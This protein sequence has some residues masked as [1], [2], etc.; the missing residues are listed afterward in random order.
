MINRLSKAKS[1]KAQPK[2]GKPA[3][4]SRIV[5]SA[6]TAV[7]AQIEQLSASDWT[8]R[9]AAAR[10]LGKLGGRQATSALCGA[11]RDPAAEVAREA[12][13]ALGEIR[14]TPAVP[15]LAAVVLNA[16][17]Y[18][19][20]SVRTAAAEAL[21]K[22]QDH[23]AVEALITAVYDSLAEVSQAAIRA[24]GLIGDER[25]IDS[26]VSV[27][28][29]TD[30]YYLGFVRQAAVEALGRLAA[31]S[32]RESLRNIAADSHLDASVRQAAD[33]VLLTATV[34]N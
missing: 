1:R 34:A 23:R 19:D 14:D 25:A 3:T 4:A 22:F 8:V 15:S 31:P 13:T 28:R 29:N 32:A 27:V 2:A 18:Y 11:L 16:D 7:T 9:A 26:L 30:N 10:E 33:T 12:A 20:G 24:L 5:S 21:A 17:G 6:A